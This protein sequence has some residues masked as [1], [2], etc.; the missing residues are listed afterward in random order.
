MEMTVRESV[1]LNELQPGGEPTVNELYDLAR[2]LKPQEFRNLGMRIQK[3][4]DEEPEK[5]AI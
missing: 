3:D 2:K 1:D 5:W 4:I